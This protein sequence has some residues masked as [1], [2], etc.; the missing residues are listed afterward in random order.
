MAA[1]RSFLV[2]VKDP[3]SKALPAIGKA[4]KLAKAFNARLDLYHG[5]TEPILADSYFYGNGELAKLRHE[6][7][8]SY[9]ERLEA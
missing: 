4:A 8:A 2:A 1:M 5:I 7:R 6:T 9:L 3:G